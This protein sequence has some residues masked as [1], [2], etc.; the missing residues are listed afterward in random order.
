MLRLPLVVALL[1]LAVRVEAQTC[2]GDFDGDGHV[3]ISELITAVGNALGGCADPTPTVAPST[4]PTALTET[5]RC[6]FEGRYS[7]RDGCRTLAAGTAPHGL[8]DLPA[9]V[10]PAD[11]NGGRGGRF[12]Q[13]P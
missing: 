9:P 11:K 5:G 8:R 13:R 4:C 3:E 12:D 7:N 2:D 1:C 6:R 10:Q